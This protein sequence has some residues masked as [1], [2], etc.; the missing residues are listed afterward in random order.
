MFGKTSMIA[1]AATAAMSVCASAGTIDMEY[2]GVQ[3]GGSAATAR[4]ASSTYYAGHMNHTITSGD[5]AGESFSTFCIEIGE[6]ANNGS[7]TYQ[8]IDLADAPLPGMAYGQ[9]KADAVSA[10]VANAVA[11][12]WIDGNLQA[13][14]GQSGYLAKMGAI[15]AAIWEALGHDFQVNSGS[16]STSLRNHY[17]ELMNSDE[18]NGRTFDSSLRLQGLRAAVASGEQDMLYVVPLP[19]AAFAGLGLMGGLMG[20]RAVRRR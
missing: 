20:V 12:G 3:G 14:T 8:I 19:P 4:V 6:A 13:D 5:R 16:T 18:N 17:N 15:Q 2:T 9:A 7:S 10:V 11:M 1:F